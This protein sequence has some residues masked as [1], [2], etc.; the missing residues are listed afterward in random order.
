MLGPGLI[1]G[2]L[3]LALRQCYPQARLHV[4]ARRPETVAALQSQPGIVDLATTDLGAA[5]AGMEC[6]VLAMPTGSMAAVVEMLPELPRLESGDPVLVT[7]VGSVKQPVLNSVSP[8]VAAR[9]GEFI[10]SHPMAGSEKKGLDY[11]DAALFENAS[12]ILTPVSPEQVMARP[13]W[14]LAQLW[15]DVGARVSVLSAARHDEIV[16]AIS[17]LPHLLAAALVNSALGHDPEAAGYC[18]GG[19]RDTTRI[20]G[21]P[22]EMWSHIL[23]DNRDAVLVQLDRLEAELSQWRA[24]LTAL[25][26]DSLQDS[27]NRACQLRAQV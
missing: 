27:L 9:G 13:W 20:S 19:F 21:G 12:V 18:G 17:H 2:S 3:V 11:A 16:A 4:W 5:V 7:D 23:A 25:D 14:R 22:P 24:H 15:G 26:R 1:G 10:G 8:L 6:L